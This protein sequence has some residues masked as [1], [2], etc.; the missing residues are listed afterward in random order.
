MCLERHIIEQCAPTLA[1][2]KTGALFGVIESD[3]EELLSQ[4]EQWRAELEPRGLI[5]M[6]L[7]IK[8]D[9]ALIYLGRRSQLRRDLAAPDAERILRRFGYGGC[10]A[11]SALE[12]LRSRVAG[13]GSFPHEIGLFLGYPP[14]DVLG[15]IENRGGNCKCCGC[16]K[17]YGDEHGAR[18]F[19]ARCRSCSAA[20]RRL[21]GRGL[22]LRELTVTA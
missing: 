8:S 7:R 22:G 16:W 14:A 20:Y 17:V 10:D 2:I 11:E 13:G 5:L 12:I 15:Y 21:Y 6:P 1:S 4:L 19:F 9:R 3:T 18:R